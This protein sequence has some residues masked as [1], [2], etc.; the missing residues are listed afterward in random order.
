MFKIFV[1]IIFKFHDFCVLKSPAQTAF[2]TFIGTFSK[3]AELLLF[4]EIG[5]GIGN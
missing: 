3:V 5:R 2:W 1:T 4:K